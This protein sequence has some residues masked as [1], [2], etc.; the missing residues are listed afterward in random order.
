[1]LAVIYAFIG[2]L[3]SKQYKYSQ[4]GDRLTEQKKLGAVQTTSFCCVFDKSRVKVRQRRTTTF[5][6]GDLKEEFCKRVC[7]G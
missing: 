3:S 7:Q 1:M 4:F 5:L 2:R 6:V